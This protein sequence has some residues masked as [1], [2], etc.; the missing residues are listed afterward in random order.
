MSIPGQAA[1]KLIDS[2]H[3]SLTNLSA[4]KEFCEVTLQN[5]ILIDIACLS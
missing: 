3:N 1:L 4:K 5:K 2:Y